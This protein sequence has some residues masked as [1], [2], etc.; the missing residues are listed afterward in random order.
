VYKF[1]NAIFVLSLFLVPFISRSEA[2][3]EQKHAVE[4][5]F[6]QSS[7][8]DYL[9]Y[10]LYRSM[11][12]FSQLETDVPMGK[13]PSLD[14]LISLP[15]QAASAQIRNYRQLYSMIHQHRGATKTIVPVS[16][17]GRTHFRKLAYSDELPSYERLSDIVH[18]GEAVYPAFESFWE[19]NIAP[20]EKQ[21]IDAWMQQLSECSPLDKLQDVE[22]LSFPFPIL[23]VGSIALHL[24]GSGNTYPPGVYTGLFKKPNLAWVI[25]HEA[26]H[27]M[28]D[29]YAGHKWRSYSLAQQA[30]ELVTEHGGHANDI[31]ESLALFMQVKLSQ[32]CGYSESTR[33]MSDN[34]PANT[35]TGAIL[36]SF[37]TGWP[38]YQANSGQDIIEYMLKQT[39]AAF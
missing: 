35:P 7:Y 17:T 29:Q 32:I 36:R 5:R 30:I 14:Q 15:E 39:I 10:L 38:E 23:D 19:K 18:Q 33:R 9:F 26:T 2:V 34:F 3:K 27:L 11:G 25:G 12:Q 28:V 37:E 8:A 20:A 21:Q 1:R 22:R 13:I 16:E 24:S 31:E 4:V 6:I